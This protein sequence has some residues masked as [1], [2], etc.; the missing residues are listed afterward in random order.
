LTDKTEGK[1]R[2]KKIKELN[3]DRNKRNIKITMCLHDRRAMAVEPKSPNCPCK[4]SFAGGV[5]VKRTPELM[6]SVCGE[7]GD[8]IAYQL[9]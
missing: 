1:R 9:V 2:T 7:G 6:V 5:L 4:V 3:K 8:V